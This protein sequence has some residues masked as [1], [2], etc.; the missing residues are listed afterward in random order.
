MLQD[1]DRDRRFSV[2]R[3]NR[4]GL[5][6]YKA[7]KYISLTTGRPVS[8]LSRKSFGF[9]GQ[10]YVGDDAL[11]GGASQRFVVP[12]PCSQAHF[13]ALGLPFCTLIVH[14]M[15]LIIIIIILLL[16]IVLID[17]CNVAGDGRS[18]CS[19]YFLLSVSSRLFECSQHNTFIVYYARTYNSH[20]QHHSS[21]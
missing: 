13:I 2:W 7:A 4:G 16:F 12:S 17:R 1:Q 14:L 19:S 3:P 9:V 21:S 10:V 6:D 5:E 8:M 18:Y 15:P 20:R 11:C